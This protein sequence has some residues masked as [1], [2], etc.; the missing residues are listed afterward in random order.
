VAELR[1]GQGV[2]AYY[3]VDDGARAQE[4]DVVP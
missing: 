4:I 1:A 2:R 3:V